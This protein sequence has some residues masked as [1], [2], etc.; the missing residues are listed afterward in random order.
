M[1]NTTL[2]EWWAKYKDSQ[3][4]LPN[5]TE[6]TENA[7]GEQE[8]EDTEGK[9]DNGAAEEEVDVREELLTKLKTAIEL[10]SEVGEKVL[11]L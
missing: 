3:K 9:E 6:D 5:D 2:E 1:S 4:A 7:E 11:K 10:I 8:Q